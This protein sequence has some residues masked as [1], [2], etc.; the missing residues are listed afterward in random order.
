MSENLT[1]KA[2]RAA[3]PDFA[4]TFSYEALVTRLP[5]SLA[6][7]EDVAP[8]PKPTYRS[9]YRYLGHADLATAKSRSVL[10]RFEI[11]L[12]LV[13]F[14]NLRDLL[15]SQVYNDSKR[16]QIPFDPVS[17]FLCLLLR[18]EERLSWRKLALRLA[19]PQ[20]AEW[21]RLFGFDTGLTP[22]ASGLRHFAEAI[23]PDLAE[24]LCGRFVRSLVSQN[25]IPRRSTYPGDKASCGASICRDGQLHTARDKLRECSCDLP[26][27]QKV[28]CPT[29]N[30]RDH[31]ASL[32]KYTGRNKHA[33][34]HAEAKFSKLVF[35]YRS[36]ADRLIDDRFATAWTVRT[37]TYTATTDEHTVFEA[38]LDRLED[39]LG[40]VS[41]AEF[42]ADAGLGYGPALTIL[43]QRRILRMVDTRAHANDNSLELQRERAYD[44]HGRPL[45]IHGFA[46]SANGYDYRRRRSKFIC[47]Q[48]CLRQT[49]RPV[50][51]C[52]FLN[53]SSCGQVVN[54]GLTTPDGSKRLARDILPGSPA[55][56]ARY[57]RRNLAESRN[58]I[59][60][61]LGLLRLPCHGLRRARTTI[62]LADCLANFNNLGSLL[63]EASS[64]PS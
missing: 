42:L 36:T 8:S 7:E 46:M 22:S 43:Y 55:W 27:D 41:I 59:L 9:H 57:G 3:H 37:S 16:G 45:C 11:T 48:A 25:L 63:A 34:S 20:G 4:K 10:S 26:C 54:I 33:D 12:R 18:L 23:G 50:P 24:Q 28:V 49:G 61:R 64:L 40:D 56:K 13:D 51:D 31:E 47:N 38:E 29:A 62:A 35:G 39:L 1:A 15:A 60:E 14:S 6:V 52:P 53:K 44:Q 17:M 58:A 19:G 32:I 5:L 30:P 21:R 2:K